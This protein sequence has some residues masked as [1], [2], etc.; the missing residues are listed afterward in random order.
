M[1]ARVALAFLGMM[2]AGCMLIDPVSLVGCKGPTCQLA[3][4]DPIIS[5]DGVTAT[6]PFLCRTTEWTPNTPK[7]KYEKLMAVAYNREKDA[8][9]VVPFSEQELTASRQ[10]NGAPAIPEHPE[11]KR[12][13]AADCSKFAYLG[14]VDWSNP[15]Y[16][17]EIFYSE[18]GQVR[19]LSHNMIAPFAVRISA[20]GQTVLSYT[21]YNNLAFIDVASS[22]VTIVP[23]RERIWE[24][25]IESQKGAV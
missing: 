12:S 17:W 10:N 1:P 21:T 20:D 13:C 4:Y 9:R 24:A 19:Q 16:D 18:H 5:D 3:Q 7:G 22:T 6:I 2:L 15:R 14:R 23:I 11:T 25:C 8:W